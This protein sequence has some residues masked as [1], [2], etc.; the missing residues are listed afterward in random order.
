MALVLTGASVVLRD[1]VV[2]ADLHLDEGQ[3]AGIGEA[4]PGIARLD[5]ADCIILPGFVDL[6]TDNVERHVEPRPGMFWSPDQAVLAHDAELAGAGITTAF[7]AITL[8]RGF[9]EQTRQEIANR[10]IRVFDRARGARLLRID[11][12]L[13]VRC[14]LSDAALPAIIAQLGPVRPSLVSLMNH[15]PGQRQWRD[16]SRFHTHYSHRYGL[17]EPQ[18]RELIAARQGGEATVVPENRQHATALAT[19]A[20]A[21]LASHD[22][23]TAADVDEA[24]AIGCCLSEFPTSAEAAA[25]A[26]A[27][28]LAVIAGAPNLVCGASH[29]G[30]VSAMDLARSGHVQML[31]S[32]YCPSSLLQAVFLLHEREGWPLADAARL[33]SLAP[34]R[35]MG[36]DDRGEIAPGRRADVIV[37]QQTSLG[38]VI[39]ETWANG[40]CVF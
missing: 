20:Q 23:T 14:E 31:A 22:D 8:G 6:H 11:H 21:R 26:A 24:A 9:P 32:D 18:L 12:R 4:P 33:V 40:V 27:R 3:I 25:Q 7:D 5:C 35:A 37:A 29:S 1:R 38:P 17:A 13:H 2:R 30:N 28:G 39:R 16:L 10:V 36:L 34:A 19:R 15:T